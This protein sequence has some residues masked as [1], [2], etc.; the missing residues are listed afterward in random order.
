MRKL[1]YTFSVELISKKYVKNISISDRAHDRV[2]FE[3][4]LGGLLSLAFIDGELL[5][6]EGLNGIARITLTTEYLQRLLNNPD[7]VLSLSS[8]LESFKTPINGE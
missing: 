6:I 4:D 8:E 5:E 3:G 1:G 2:L 7:Q